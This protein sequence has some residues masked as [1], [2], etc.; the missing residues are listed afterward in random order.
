MRRKQRPD[1]R[2][3]GPA[4]MRERAHDAQESW[5]VF[6]RDFTLR[7]AALLIDSSAIDMLT[8][9]GNALESLAST[10]D[11]ESK[12]AC[13][14]AGPAGRKVREACYRNSITIAAAGYRMSFLTQ[15]MR[16]HSGDMK[17]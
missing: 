10:T 8:L 5:Q 17:P 1:E 3:P 11:A 12:A 4:S 6:H 2:T 16:F 15:M 13:N 14:D 7:V 9:I